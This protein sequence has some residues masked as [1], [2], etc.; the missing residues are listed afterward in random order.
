MISRR[1]AVA[2]SVMS[3]PLASVP[4][5]A[6]PSQPA[7][8]T[9]AAEPSGLFRLERAPQQGG[10]TRGRVPPNTIR[11]VLD[12]Q[13]VPFAPDRR[14]IIG[15]GR[16]YAESALLTAFFSDGTSQSQTVRVAPS[17]WI[18]ENLS[19]LPHHAGPDAAFEAR[20]SA[21]LDQIA[22]A[23]RI[24]TAAQG[25]RQDFIW[26]VPGRIT[27]QFG[28]QRI[29]AGTPGAPHAGVDLAGAVGTPVVS[30]ADGVVIL[31][32]ETPFS[33]EGHLVLL[34]HGLG[35]NSAF[36]HL[37][38]IDVKP[39][40]IIRQGQRIGAVGKTGRATGPHLHWG[41]KWNN[42]RIDPARFALPPR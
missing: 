9:Q 17:R 19:R 40:E 35:L 1:M 6:S 41:L 29:Y 34:D 15:F 36:L 14:F 4:A 23:R 32:T 12:G 38:R 27:G 5:A 18:I 33:L 22:A 16:D 7:T 28:A 11:F 21:E 3:I 39:G 42:E 2:L 37:S 25:W 31:A 13:D 24:T 20:R 10:L 26:P 8:T 30:P